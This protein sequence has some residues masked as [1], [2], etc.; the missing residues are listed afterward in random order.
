VDSNHRPFRAEY[1]CLDTALWPGG[2]DEVLS[3]KR[4][5][6]GRDGRF[7]SAFLQRGVARNQVEAAAELVAPANAADPWQRQRS[8]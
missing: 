3:E 5:V 6:L 8:K 7:E 1:L 4:P 2:V